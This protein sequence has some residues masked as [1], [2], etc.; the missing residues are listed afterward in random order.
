MQCEKA[1]R[2]HIGHMG[3]EADAAV[4]PHCRRPEGLRPKSPLAALLALPIFPIWAAASA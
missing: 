4:R 3:S 1:E 2:A